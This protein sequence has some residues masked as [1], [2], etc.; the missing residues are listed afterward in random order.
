MKK[1]DGNIGFFDV[2][3]T[4][5]YNDFMNEYS[6]KKAKLLNGEEIE[7]NSDQGEIWYSCIP[8]FNTTQILTP[9]NKSVTVPQIMWDKFMFESDNVYINL[10][11]M[12]HHGFCDAFH[13]GEF[14]KNFEDV[15]KNIESYLK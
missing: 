11:I 13:L 6:D 10:T 7:I 14:I 1:E 2:K 12:V 8:W 15:V 5:N 3:Y 4:N 9:F